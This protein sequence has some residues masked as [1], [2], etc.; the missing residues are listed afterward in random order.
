MKSFQYNHLASLLATVA[1]PALVSIASAE[2]TMELRPEAAA[3]I[4]SSAP[5]ETFP[6]DNLWVNGNDQAYR[7]NLIVF[8]LPSDLEADNGRRVLRAELR[9]TQAAFSGN[10]SYRHKA[11]LHG[12]AD[13]GDWDGHGSPTWANAPKNDP[14]AAGPVGEGVRS[15]GS[16]GLRDKAPSFDVTQFV[17]WALGGN[18]AYGNAPRDDDRRITFY[19]SANLPAVYRYHGL[20][21]PDG[22]RLVIHWDD[23]SYDD[24]DPAARSA[25]DAKSKSNASPET[26]DVRR[27][28]V[29]RDPDGKIAAAL[30]SLVGDGE[31]DDTAA[32]QTLFG[33]RQTVEIPSGVYRVTDTLR[34]ASGT[35]ISGAGGAWNSSA[36]GGSVIYYDGEPGGTL[37]H[38][39]NAHFFQMSEIALNGHG[40]AAIGVYWNYST[41]DAAMTDVTI[42]DT[43][44]HALYITRTWY[45]HFTRVSARGNFGRGVTLDR[46]HFED[47]AA[48]PVNFVTFQQCQFSH[49]GKANRY[50]PET[51]IDAGYGFGSFGYNNM[52]NI[53]ACAMEK[54]G[55]AGVYIGGG[56][57][58]TL[59]FQGCYI[60]YNC[61][62][63]TRRDKELH[64]KD[65]IRRTDRASV[66]RIANVISDTRG[67]D[68]VT[69]DTCYFHPYGGIWLKD[70][71]GGRNPIIFKQTTSPTVVW[72]EHDDY[73][74][75]SRWQPK[76]ADQPGII[77]REEKK[78]KWLPKE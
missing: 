3:H 66:G 24:L 60:E 58:G 28:S 2:R 30:D 43:T 50:D 33:S 49:S 64:G 20:N 21:H 5:N 15:L 11:S 22:P 17:R 62:T 34:A 67:R 71:P 41:Q 47:L 6:P 75:E 8:E 48:G 51:N 78:W 65:A 38:V 46:G 31:A 7:S 37:L 26:F 70:E 52:I 61:D 4:R 14:D 16:A 27:P 39:E 42:S 73:V 13:N 76:F 72:A 10:L 29:Q 45:A 1:L 12:I 74:F 56:T 57:A 69:F 63:L 55:G 32:L 25:A 54:N 68:A 23:G 77:V 18:P 53:L 44:E 59:L 9:L 36:S 40:K 35:R 19:L